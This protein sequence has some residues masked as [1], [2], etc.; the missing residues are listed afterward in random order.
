[1]MDPALQPV[2]PVVVGQDHM[3]VVIADSA[4]KIC[5]D[6]L[7]LVLRYFIESGLASSPFCERDAF[8]DHNDHFQPGCTSAT[9]SFQ[10]QGLPAG[11]DANIFMPWRL[12]VFLLVQ[13]L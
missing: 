11:F 6:C 4:H 13:K 5:G 1:M 10:G 12:R 3:S 7:S 9:L 2:F 8:E